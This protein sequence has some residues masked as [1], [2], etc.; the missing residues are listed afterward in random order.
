[1]PGMMV[2]EGS[3][4]QT[5]SGEAGAPADPA[6]AR[7]TAADLGFLP[8]EGEWRKTIGGR[9]VAFRAVRRLVDLA[10]VEALQQAVFGVSDRDLAA[11][12][13]LVIVPETGGEVIGAY[14]GDELIGFVVG[15]GGYVDGRP[16]LLSDMLGVRADRR[17]GGLGGEL[18]KLQAVLA[19]DRGITEV[20]WTVDPLRAA[21]ARL[22]FEKLGAHADRYEIDRY[23]A[24]YGAGLYGGLPT[25][26]LHV[27]WPLTSARVHD[28]LLGRTA[29]TTAADIAGLAPFHSGHSG[30][31]A[32]VALPAD[33]DR[34]LPTDPAAVRQ[35]RA[36]LRDAL[37]AAFAEGYVIT[38]FVGAAPGK[39][40]ATYVLERDD[41]SASNPNAAAAS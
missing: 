6:L 41:H 26:R 36:R 39:D 21:N 32:V 11:A 25:D 23:G 30:P 19:L 37:T 5:S 18:K 27:T 33:V 15:W 24:E 34:L 38:G 31:R 17:G 8:V 29:M 4:A 40:R 2:S 12:S 7:F 16:R 14:D 35:W 20:V 1:M 13:F 28:R 10:A 9:E 22:N 3:F